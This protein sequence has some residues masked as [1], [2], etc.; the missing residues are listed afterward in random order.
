MD[1]PDVQ[2]KQKPPER[3]P[4][5]AVCYL[6]I[7]IFCFFVSPPSSQL[8][9]AKLPCQVAMMLTGVLQLLWPVLPPKARDCMV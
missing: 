4:V 2:K 1:P 8:P 9:V 5:P 3:L 7:L 6:L